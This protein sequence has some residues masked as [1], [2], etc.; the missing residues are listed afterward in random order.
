MRGSSGEDW[1][2]RMVHG[3]QLI[4][5]Y[6]DAGGY[7]VDSGGDDSGSSERAV[8]VVGASELWR[9]SRLVYV[10][11]VHRRAVAITRSDRCEY[12]GQPGS[13]HALERAN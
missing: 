7:D 8:R 6:S 2:A 1:G 11:Y 4:S 13:E 3:M 10:H 12:K 9:H 5:R